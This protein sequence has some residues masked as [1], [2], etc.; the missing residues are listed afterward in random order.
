MNSIRN[1]NDLARGPVPAP[2]APIRTTTFRE[3]EALSSW[4]TA[5]IPALLDDLVRQPA[6]VVLEGAVTDA[7]VEAMR[8]AWPLAWVVRRVS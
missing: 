8:R 2:Q 5:P 7:V 6:T 3:G 1:S 4:A